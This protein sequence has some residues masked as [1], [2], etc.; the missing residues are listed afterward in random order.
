[1]RHLPLAAL[2]SLAATAARADALPPA[3]GPAH[4]GVQICMSQQVCRCAHDAGGTLSGRVAGW[5][6]SCD[7]MQTCDMDVPA[8]LGPPQSAGGVG[9]VYVTPNVTSP[10]GAGTQSGA[11]PSGAMPP[12]AMPQ[13]AMPPPWRRP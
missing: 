4:D 2:L 3:C 11:I 10:T 12:G 6:W 1:M 5:R 7:I 8:D 13:G 9:P